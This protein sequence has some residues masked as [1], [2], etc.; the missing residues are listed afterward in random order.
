GN[1]N[2]QKKRGLAS[3]NQEAR[4]R[5]MNQIATQPGITSVKRLRTAKTQIFNDRREWELYSNIR[6]V[7]TLLEDINEVK[8][9]HKHIN[10]VNRGFDLMDLIKCHCEEHCAFASRTIWEDVRDE[11][12]TC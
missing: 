3:F 1:L 7:K 2:H 12:H 10:S 4:G 11:I 6:I 5:N 9:T 8:R